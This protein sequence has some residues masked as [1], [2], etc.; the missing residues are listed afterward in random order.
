MHLY[1]SICM[2]IFNILCIISQYIFMAH[3]VLSGG[4]CGFQYFLRIHTA[5][6]KS[7]APASRADWPLK[8]LPGFVWP[9]AP[10]NGHARRRSTPYRAVL[11]VPLGSFFRA[12]LPAQGSALIRAALKVRKA[13]APLCA[14]VY[15]APLAALVGPEPGGGVI[16]P[17]RV[18]L[19]RPRT[20]PYRRTRALARMPDAQT[21]PLF[22]ST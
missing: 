12:I 20:A 10:A 8:D 13:P 17:A 6:T 11:F 19:H 1:A 14:R 16:G 7:P 9:Y 5:R 21:R 18:E 4:M 2:Y 3:A 15:L 22:F